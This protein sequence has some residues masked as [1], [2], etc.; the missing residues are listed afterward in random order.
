M[1]LW[2]QK[3]R[4]GK[5]C[6]FVPYIKINNYE[7]SKARQV[8]AKLKERLII[9][10]GPAGASH[11][12]TIYPVPSVEI[13]DLSGAGDTFIS[14]LATKYVETNSIEEAIKFANECATVVVQKAG[15]S[16]I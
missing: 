8:T 15:V 5:W 14:A 13:K 12:S 3:K 9:T 1:C 4:F 11:K 7:L 2:I 10:L 6:E 16:V